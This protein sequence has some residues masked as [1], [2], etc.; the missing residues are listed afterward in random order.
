MSQKSSPR[1]TVSVEQVINQSG[2]ITHCVVKVGDQVFEAPFNIGHTDLGEIIEDAT[3][4]VLNVKEHMIVTNSSR[5]QTE[6]EGGRLKEVLLTMAEGTVALVEGELYFWLNSDKELVWVECMR[7][8]GNPNDMFPGF[9]EEFGEIDT[10]ELYQ[11]AEHIRQWL[12][13]PKTQ[14]MDLEW[15]RAVEN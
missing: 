8:D 11:N 2:D 9:I 1:P 7:V 13:E 12:H 4:V 15:L 14:V 6:R 5:K 3:G 10:D